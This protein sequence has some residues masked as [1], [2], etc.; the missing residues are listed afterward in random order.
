METEV[1][2]V[3]K[4]FRDLNI[5]FKQMVDLVLSSATRKSSA[6]QAVQM[7]RNTLVLFSTSAM[8]DYYSLGNFIQFDFY[9][10]DNDV[11]QPY[12]NYSAIF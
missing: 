4:D 5:T 9:V 11:G 6:S 7:L 10:I 2:S 12:T 8:F 3:D 1:S